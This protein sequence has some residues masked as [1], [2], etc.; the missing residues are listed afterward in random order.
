MRAAGESAGRGHPGAPDDDLMVSMEFPR[1]PRDLGN[2]GLHRI[3]P[4]GSEALH[5]DAVEPQQRRDLPR[6]RGQVVAGWERPRER[7]HET[8][9]DREAVGPELTGG[10]QLLTP[11]PYSPA[12]ARRAWGL[13][14]PEHGRLRAPRAEL[15]GARPS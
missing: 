4:L 8:V 11:P 13:H 1:G 10:E 9:V 2:E 15:V 14:H 12:H 6:G 7:V 5:V 3:R